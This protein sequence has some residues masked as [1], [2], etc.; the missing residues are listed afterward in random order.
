[1]RDPE[2]PGLGLEE[3][4]PRGRVGQGGEE[5][6]GEAGGLAHP[7]DAAEGLGQVAAHGPQPLAPEDRVGAVRGHEVEREEPG[8]PRRVDGELTQEGSAVWA[9]R[10]EP[11]A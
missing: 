6:R 8:L 4:D 11:G 10:G 9:R 2:P 7:L 5:G 1:M 3:Q